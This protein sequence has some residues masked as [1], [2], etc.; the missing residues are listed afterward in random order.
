MMASELCEKPVEKPFLRGYTPLELA[1]CANGFQ[2]GMY[3]NRNPVRDSGS[4]RDFLDEDGHPD[5]ENNG[6]RDAGRTGGS[7]REN[8]E[9][10]L[11]GFLRSIFQ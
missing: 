5:Y 8:G 3:G 10:G 9:K 2:G 1:P 7:S 4:S 11:S 6:S